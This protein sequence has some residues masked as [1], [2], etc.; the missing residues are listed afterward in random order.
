MDHP[1]RNLGSVLLLALPLLLGFFLGLCAGP[2]RAA[3]SAGFL[4]LCLLLLFFR[5]SPF[6]TSL[7]VAAL[8]GALSAG[9]LPH[10]APEHV[11]PFLGAEVALRGNV[12]Q[13]RHTDAGWSGVVEGAEVSLPDGSGS[14][15]PG[16]ILLSVWN[17]D[18]AVSFPAEVR[19]TGRLHPIQSLGNP[20]EIPR[21]W[22]ALMLRVQYRFSA[23]ASRAV[24]LPMREGDGGVLGVFRRGR[25]RTEKWLAVHAGDSDGAL[26]LRALTTGE[27]PPPSH[28]MVRLLQRTGLAHLLAISG[29]NVA[30][31]YL[32]H[33][34]LVRSVLWVLR[35]RHGTPDLNR[36]SALLSLP[37]CWGYALMAG[38]P[39]SA[40]R[41]AGMLT[42][43]VFL[44]YLLG[45]RGSGAAW[46][47]LFLSTIVCAPSWIFSPSFLLSYGASFFLIVAFA[48]NRRNAPRFPHPLGRALGWA[49]NAVVG[50]S[51][52]FLGTLP[53]SAAFFERLP[54][55]AILWNVLFAPLLGSV[56]VAGAFLG[57]AGGV[58]SADILGRA[59][60]IVAEILGGSLAV[61]S[62]VSG[63]GS[64]WFPLP[65][66]GL[67]A[68][69]VCTGAAAF[70]SL[71]LR[72]RGRE[73]LP[74]VAA[75]VAAF[76]AWIHVPYAALPDHRLT[77]A[78]LN[79]GKG[80]AHV[81]SFPGG[82]HMLVDCGSGLRGDAGEKVVLPYV[83]SRGIRRIDVLVLTH[84]HE[85]H[86]G[87][88]T[89]VLRSLPVGEI[90]IPEGMPPASFGEAVGNRADRV[91]GKSRGDAYASGGAEVIVR[92]VEMT[93]DH[94]GPNERSLL[95]GIRYGSFSA[96]LPGDVERG[97]SAWGE[98][99]REEEGGKRVVFLPHHGSPGAQPGAWIRAASPAAVVSQNRD[100]FRKGNLVPSLQSFFL[101][102]GAVTM[103]SDG[104]SVFIE[105]E[106]R[107]SFWKLSL[108]L[109]P[110][111]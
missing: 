15:R 73:P 48:G 56:G 58:F 16:R 100:C 110:E 23:E 33:A 86:Y 103:R 60:R 5:V 98:D 45:V 107:P 74:A 72:S 70:G 66:T 97:P 43:V 25:A 11:R 51:M 34:F 26:F 57:A 102:N 77:V 29:V 91:R 2:C 46:T 79:V 12:F 32:V 63:N 37:V 78:A 65:P 104:V 87:G 44:R 75:A 61:L 3:V 53:V 80:A 54:A 68:P 55:G 71:W 81:V 83:R 20:G 4:F 21:E 27:S 90:W 14:I 64:W 6:G 41:A 59:V 38:S 106:R 35:R 95:L 88:A 85:D 19:A 67:A 111:E 17:P 93:G 18:A 39:V 1:F 99:P 52:A 47:A 10:L 7:A 24:F 40:I 28:P 30:I 49:R 96:W 36:S 92:G 76:L 105:Q 89:A 8:C 9:R 13:V 42:V 84:P 50:S 69:L 108:R 82:G 101:E 109:P 62:R 31:F 94:R 22:T